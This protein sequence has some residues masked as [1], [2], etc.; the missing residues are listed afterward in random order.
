MTITLTA[1]A[2]ALIQQKVQ[3]GLYANPEEAIEAAVRLLDEHDRRLQ[4]LRTAIA[5]GEEGEAIPW[6]PELMDQ[7]AREA[8]E[9]YRRGEMPDPDVRP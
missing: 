1:E 8:E 2:E 3:S 5:E 6:T 4:R 9:M 7:L